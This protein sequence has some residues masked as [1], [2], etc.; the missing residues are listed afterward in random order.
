[1]ILNKVGPNIESYG[2]PDKTIWKARSAIYFYTLFS[3]F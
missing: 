2:I 3:T 1:M